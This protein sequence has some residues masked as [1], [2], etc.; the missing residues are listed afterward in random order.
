MTVAAPSDIPVAAI[1]LGTNSF[2]MVIARPAGNGR[3]E[4][5][6]REKE[7]VR[8]GSGS[9][10]MKVL[11]PDAIDRAVDSLRRMRQLAD[12]AG[13]EVHAVATSAVREAGNRGE[14]LRRAAD[15]A[16]VEVHVVSGAEEAR[17]IHLGVLQAVSIFD[18]RH[19]VVDIGGGS[20]EIIVG[21][22]A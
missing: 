3:F 12:R 6:D 11:A 21:E 4:V 17:L 2:H 5:I 10:D 8:L 22:G 16:G 20:T 7:V 18:Q 15:E 9:G 19:L 14:L 1:D 13:A